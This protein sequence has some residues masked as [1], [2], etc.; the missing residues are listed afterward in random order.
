MFRRIALTIAAC[1]T[2]Y[3]LLS[4]ALVSLALT[5]PEALPGAACT[6]P[7]ATAKRATPTVNTFIPGDGFRRPEPT[8]S[9]TP[10][11]PPVNPV[12]KNCN[13]GRVRVLV[14][15]QQ[16]F[17][18]HIG[19]VVEI[20]VWIWLDPST[21]IDFQS[22][23]SGVLKFD[24]TRAF[25]LAA[26]R[27]VQI[28][29]RPDD[30]L[31]L[32]TLVLRV[33]TFVPRQTVPFSLDLRYA[34]GL[35]DDTNSPDWQVLTTPDYL[36]TTSRTLDNGTQMQEGNMQQAQSHTLLLVPLLGLGLL[37]SWAFVALSY[38]REWLNRPGRART[39]RIDPYAAAWETFERHFAASNPNG[40]DKEDMRRIGECLHVFLHTKSCT[41]TEVE[42][43]YHDDPRLPSISA[44]LIVFDQFLYHPCAPSRLAPDE[45]ARLVALLREIVRSPN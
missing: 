39:A 19:D 2:A 4:A 28:F 30:G 32:Y 17:A 3:C 34:T 20:N 24:G 16:Q 26:D 37:S 9:P 13:N 8:P 33:Q 5:T 36:V 41:R 43:A 38:L 21:T 1:I 11:P 14:G 27:P 18:N 40:F 35:A 12:E 10:V 6:T 44:A 42:Q 22:L 23:Q 29:T 15:N 25:Q 45:Q 7:G 31:T